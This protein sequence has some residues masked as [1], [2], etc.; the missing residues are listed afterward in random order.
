MWSSVEEEER[1]PMRRCVK[2]AIM[3]QRVTRKRMWMEIEETAASKRQSTSCNGLTYRS[4]T[5]YLPQINGPYACRSEVFGQRRVYKQNENGLFMFF[6]AQR[7]SWAIADAV[8]HPAPYAFV[9][10]HAE[11]PGMAGGYF[12]R[13]TKRL[14]HRTFCR[15]LL[16][17]SYVLFLPGS[18]RGVWHVFNRER[19]FHTQ[20]PKH[21]DSNMQAVRL[22]GGGG[23]S[24][25]ID[26]HVTCRDARAL[27]IKL[28]ARQTPAPAASYQPL[29]TQM[30][31]NPELSHRPEPEV[32]PILP[33]RPPPPSLA[34]FALPPVARLPSL[35]PYMF[36]PMDTVDEVYGAEDD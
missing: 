6:H 17:S 36:P 28:S 5:K 10:D 24:F 14:C 34:S 12:T 11:H 9:D 21:R 7:G 32:A 1:Y 13:L 29:F 15:Q 8:G 20:G 33:R 27:E 23:G 25:E 22:G 18:I 4:F 2:T 31:L 16:L 30:Q 35:P 19:E 26:L 3:L